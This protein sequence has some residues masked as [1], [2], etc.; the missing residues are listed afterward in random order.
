[1]YK[2]LVPWLGELHPDSRSSTVLRLCP[3]YFWISLHFSLI[4][5]AFLVDFTRKYGRVGFFIYWMANWVTMSGLGFV[6]ETMFLWLGM[7]F[8]F[9][10]LF[11]VIINVS[12]SKDA[13]T[14]CTG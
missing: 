4:S 5:L 12:P 14:A 10:L 8:P 6:M 13:H 7:W 11:W 2:V 9:F 3:G 1:M